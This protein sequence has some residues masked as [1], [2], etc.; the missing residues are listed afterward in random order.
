MRW[1]A[2]VRFSGG[3]KSAMASC[4]PTDS[5]VSGSP[6]P[7]GLTFRAMSGAGLDGTARRSL[8]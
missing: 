3:G 1:K 2:H 6:E 7:P 4:Y 8:L 5:A